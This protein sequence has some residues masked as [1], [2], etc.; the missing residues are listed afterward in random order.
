MFICHYALLKS[1]DIDELIRIPEFLDALS[2]DRL[3]VI[4]YGESNEDLVGFIEQLVET[5][6][7][8][9]KRKREEETEEN[10]ITI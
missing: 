8:V 6:E 3:R 1:Q 4:K 7:L 2:T 10:E 5:P 9:L